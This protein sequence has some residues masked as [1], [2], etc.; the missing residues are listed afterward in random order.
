MNMCQC[1]WWKD[2]LEVEEET[3]N[4]WAK[5]SEEELWKFGDEQWFLDKLSSFNNKEVNDSSLPLQEEADMDEKLK[6]IVDEGNKFPQVSQFVSSQ[7][8]KFPC[9]MIT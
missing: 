3:R 6:Q 5:A 1:R 2:F 8:H 7:F 9:I 4:L